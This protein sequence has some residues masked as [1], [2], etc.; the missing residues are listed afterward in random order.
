MKSWFLHKNYEEEKVDKEMNKVKFN[1]HSALDKVR[2]EQVKG[3]PL[4]VTNHPCLKRIIK[5]ITDKLYL[6]Q[7]DK[8]VMETFLIKPMVSFEST[9]KLSSYL[10]QAKIYPIE[11]KDGSCCCK[12]SRC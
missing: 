4:L 7:M 5:V 6:L 12:K 9:R 3:V 1:F 2:N 8:E 11:R 10:V